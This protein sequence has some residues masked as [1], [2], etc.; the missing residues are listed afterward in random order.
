MAKAMEVVHPGAGL[1]KED[2]NAP[3][4][5]LVDGAG[6]VR[7]FLRPTRFMVR[8]SPSDVLAAIDESR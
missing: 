5:F 4:T 3:T 8:L 1:N 7:W 6:Q 2:T